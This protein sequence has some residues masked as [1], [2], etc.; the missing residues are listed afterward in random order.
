M[1]GL[2][3][4]LAELR[5]HVGDGER[6]LVE[7]GD[8]GHH[9]GL[10]QAEALEPGQLDLAEPAGRAQLFA[11]HAG[12][13]DHAR[14]RCRVRSRRALGPL[15]R[16]PGAPGPGPAGPRFPAATARPLFRTART[17]SFRAARCAPGAGTCVG[18]GTALARPS[19]RRPLRT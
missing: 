17:S 15:T 10:D 16:R 6:V 11:R 2:D 1:T 18:T 7:G 19:S 9:D 12:P 4:V 3:A 13:G 8:P 5:R 14:R